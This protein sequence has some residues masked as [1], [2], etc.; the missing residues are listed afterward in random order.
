MSSFLKDFNFI[1]SC[2]A[3]TGSKMLVHILLSN[4]E[5]MCHGEVFNYRNIGG[6]MGSYNSLRE[7][8][9]RGAVEN[10]SLKRVSI[11]G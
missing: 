1:I 11:N 10:H 5:I 9:L 3:W 8:A 6:L 2:V 7:D 4:P